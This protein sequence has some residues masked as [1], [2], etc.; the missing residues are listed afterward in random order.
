MN[1]IA[2]T[3]LSR[4]TALL[5]C[6]AT[7]L[8]EWPSAWAMVCLLFVVDWIWAS[9]VG[10]TIGGVGIKLGIIFAL[11]GFS[12]AFSCRD[13]GIANL[14]EAI[15]LLSAFTATGAV[16]TYLAATCAF[17]LQ[18]VMFAQWDRSI[19]FDWKAWQEEVRHRPHLCYLL[20]L[21]YNSMVP[22]VF[23]AVIYFSPTD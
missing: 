6:V 11:L 1:W 22:Q 15:A 12:A 17:P 14:A 18:D 8:V 4:E 20:L 3:A 16:L 13:R 2:P 23:L 21:A 19:G 5:P 7:S 9:Q 10:L